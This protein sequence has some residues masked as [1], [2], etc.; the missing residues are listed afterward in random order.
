MPVISTGWCAPSSTVGD[1]CNRFT[2]TLSRRRAPPSGV[3]VWVRP[4]E[5]GAVLPIIGTALALHLDRSED[6]GVGERSA[7]GSG[8]RR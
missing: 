2:T 5:A 3:A 8:L 7:A 6:V 4:P 1:T